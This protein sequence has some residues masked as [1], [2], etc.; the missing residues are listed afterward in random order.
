VNVKVQITSEFK[1]LN[2]DWIRFLKQ[3]W[4]NLASAV[5]GLDI[6]ISHVRKLVRHLDHFRR[7]IRFIMKAVRR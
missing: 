3:L 7:F 4:T 5:L 6:E 1:S 2:P